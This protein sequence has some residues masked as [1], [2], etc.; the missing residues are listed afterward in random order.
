MKA[1]AVDFIEKPLDDDLLLRAID[2][3]V[4]ENKPA[5]RDREATAAAEKMALLSPRERQVLEA[6]ATGQPNK[7]IAHEL[8]ISIRTVEVHRAHMLDRLGVR[9]AAEAIRIAVMSAV[10]PSVE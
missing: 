2:A 1:G 8:G 7:L 3:A 10:T 5:A 6:I 9:T 4:A